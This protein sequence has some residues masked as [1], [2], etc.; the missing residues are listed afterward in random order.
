MRF[1]PHATALGALAL[2]VAAAG[3]GGGG[4][5]KAA[6]AAGPKPCAY[7]GGW[8]R[9]ANRIAA[10]VYCPAWLPGPLTAQIGG[11]WNNIDS[12]GRDRSYLISF[13]WQDTDGPNTTGELHVNLRAY[14]ARTKIPTC[15]DTLVGGGKPRHVDIPCFADPQPSRTIAGIR[16]TPYTVNQGADQWHLLYAWRHRGSLYTVS[17]HVAPP[18][19]FAKVGRYLDRIVRGLVLIHPQQG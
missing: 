10:P 8:Q 13:V 5:A 6:A 12:V 9:L 4:P 7:P 18:L 1:L 15:Q 14:P 16:F 2:A 19:T 3:C 11:K 17:E